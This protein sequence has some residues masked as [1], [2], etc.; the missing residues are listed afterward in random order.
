MS[1]RVTDGYERAARLYPAL[2]A[3]SPALVAGAVAIYGNA[4]LLTFIVSLVSAVG[5]LFLLASVARELGKK[6][7]TQLYAEWGGE[8]STIL[9]RHRDA[10]LNPVTKTRYHAVLAEHTGISFPSPQEEAIHAESADHTYAAAATWLRNQAKNKPD[11]FPLLLKE[12]IEYGFRRNLYGVKPIAITLTL[13]VV[14]A[15]LYS[16]GAVDC[17]VPASC[18]VTSI[19]LP[20]TLQWKLGACFLWLCLW[21]VVV[22]AKWVKSAAFTYAKTLLEICEQLPMPKSKGNREKKG[23]GMPFNQSKTP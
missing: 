14:G 22:T 11:D 17:M 5:G 18:K 3:L 8:P 9:L 1:L 4:V 6:K 2:L 7:Q 23:K 21:L 19:R 20:E 12:N 10:E 16:S 15:A 13:A